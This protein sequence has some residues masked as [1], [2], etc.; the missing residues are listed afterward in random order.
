LAEQTDP[1]RIVDNIFDFQIIILFETMDTE[2][3]FAN[4]FF[5]HQLFISDFFLAFLGAI[6]ESIIIVN[7]QSVF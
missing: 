3:S 1:V 6:C 4:Q 2:P 5:V 7:W